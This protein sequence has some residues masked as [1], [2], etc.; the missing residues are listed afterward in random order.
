VGIMG[1]SAR[2]APGIKGI[3][4]EFHSASDAVGNTMAYVIAKITNFLIA[5]FADSRF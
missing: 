3:A 4:A 5:V 2:I 1:I